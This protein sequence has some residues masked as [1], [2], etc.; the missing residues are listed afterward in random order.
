MA[1]TVIAQSPGSFSHLANMPTCEGLLDGP[2]PQKR[3]DSQLKLNDAGVYLCPS[4]EAQRGLSAACCGDISTSARSDPP[5]DQIP[6]QADKLT[7][8]TNTDEGNLTSAFMENLHGIFAYNLD[9]I[10]KSLNGFSK[11]VL[12]KL[13]KSLCCKVAETFPQ[14]RDRKPI[15]RQ[16][17]KTLLYD[18]ATLGY[19]L[20]NNAP[21]K[22][23]D[24]VF[25]PLSS[26]PPAQP[27][28]CASPQHTDQ[29]DLADLLTV[30]AN[31]TSRVTQLEKELAFLQA[32]SSQTRTVSQDP[33]PKSLTIGQDGV[34]ERKAT[35]LATTP[36]T[37]NTAPTPALTT[38]LVQ[39][40]DSSSSES[41]PSEAG[42]SQTRKQRRHQRW[43]ATRRAAAESK[44]SVSAK[45]GN[46]ASQ[47]SAS[48]SSAVN[49]IAA[50]S[51]QT[52]LCS[53]YIGGVSAK[54]S[55]SDLKN[56]I[57]NMGVSSCES[58]QVLH[59]DRDW[60]SFKADIPLEQRDLVCDGK[61][62]HR[63]ITVR[64]FRPRQRQ[65]R[66]KVLQPSSGS[67]RE[68]RQRYRGHNRQ[69]LR[70][71]HHRQDNKPRSGD[72]PRGSRSTWHQ[73]GNHANSRSYEH[74]EPRDSWS[75][76]HNRQY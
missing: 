34:P 33:V 16:V 14:Y 19:S 70:G 6:V 50:A 46:S 7:L 51:P 32:Q 2:C 15:N 44:Q 10:Q 48:S 9:D 47:I 1:K 55:P 29:A 25:H 13:H 53:V 75:T 60:R 69:Q 58:V 22:D 43:L 68:Y 41:N 23:M 63:G 3:N 5:I 28:D 74:W 12:C 27:T 76:G 42:F 45:S 65:K 35:E 66:G 56:H 49:P 30:V 11:E 31:L 8:L 62:W 37:V 39:E 57:L 73:W 40:S 21:L 20:V 4:C 59:T 71:H 17:K 67:T 38:V 61:N 24:K 52:K 36:R 72:E 54:N 64:P 18:I 26:P